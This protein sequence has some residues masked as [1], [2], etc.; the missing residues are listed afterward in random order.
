MSLYKKYIKRAFALAVKRPKGWKGT[1]YYE[2]GSIQLYLKPVSKQGD[3]VA[4]DF[5]FGVAG[6]INKNSAWI[7]CSTNTFK[8]SNEVGGTGDWEDFPPGGRGIHKAACTSVR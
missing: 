7:N 3:I 8:V 2:Q 6:E 4:I 5:K 1:G